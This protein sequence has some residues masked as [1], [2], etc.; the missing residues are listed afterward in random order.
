MVVARIEILILGKG[1][2]DVLKGPMLILKLTIYA[3]ETFR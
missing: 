1:L 2:D 3:D